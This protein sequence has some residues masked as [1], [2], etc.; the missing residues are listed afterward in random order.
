MVWDG[1]HWHAVVCHRTTA[2]SVSSVKLASERLIL[3]KLPRKLWKKCR[4]HPVGSRIKLSVMLDMSG[5]FI[6]WCN[7]PISY[8]N[9]TQTS[10]NICIWIQVVLLFNSVRNL[11][12]FLSIT[13]NLW[14]RL[15]VR[16]KVV[17]ISYNSPDMSTDWINLTILCLAKWDSRQKIHKWTS[18][19]LK[20]HISLNDPLYL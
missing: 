1:W 6:W 10:Q 11:C 20:Q 18:T 14:K 8:N 13:V 19:L 3:K 4:I 15:Y 9:T 16:V 17:I 12:T 5:S 2:A 7:I